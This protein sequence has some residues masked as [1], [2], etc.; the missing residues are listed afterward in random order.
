MRIMGIDPGLSGA[1]A[2]LDTR[3][4]EIVLADMPVVTLSTKTVRKGGRKRT[5][6]HKVVDGKA[7]GDWVERHRPDVAVVEQ[8]GSRP[9][10]GVVSVFNFGEAF[11]A[12]T[13]AVTAMNVPLDRVYPAKWK[14][15]LGLIGTDKRASI[16]LARR[17]FK[18]SVPFLSRAK[19]HGRAEALLLAHYRSLQ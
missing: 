18:K 9:E 3:T 6:V 13:G 12:V 5:K 4:K 7:V 14:R 2:L 10:Q 15:A 11:G 19:D 17:K 16:K 8:V 1:L